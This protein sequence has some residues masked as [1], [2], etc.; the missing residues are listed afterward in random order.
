MTLAMKS[1]MASV[2]LLLGA[3][4]LVTHGHF[5]AET[6]PLTAGEIAQLTDGMEATVSA[7]IVS[8][9][10]EGAT[11]R[12]AAVGDPE[13]LDAAGVEL[14]PVEQWASLD[15]SGKRLILTQVVINQAIPSCTIDRTKN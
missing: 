6:G 5:S 10:V 3:C 4:D 2:A 15:T 13:Q 11:L 14:L 12:A 8:C 9:I 7:E 1:T